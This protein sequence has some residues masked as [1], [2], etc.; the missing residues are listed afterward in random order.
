MELLSVFQIAFL[1]SHL[2]FYPL[3]VVCPLDILD[4]P[5]RWLTIVGQIV[6]LKSDLLN[7]ENTV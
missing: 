4:H 6:K 1:N 2:L 3:D 7:V 5:K